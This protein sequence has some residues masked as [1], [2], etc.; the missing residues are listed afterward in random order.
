MFAVSKINQFVSNLE[1]II[2]VLLSLE[3]VMHYLRGT[4]SLGVHNTTYMKVLVSYFD[5]N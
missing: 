4:M 2:G 3:R 5:A 1:M